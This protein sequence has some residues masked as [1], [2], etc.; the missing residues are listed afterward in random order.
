MKNS[1]LIFLVCLGCLFNACK[2]D[3]SLNAPHKD[4]PIVYGILNYQDSIHYVKI[5]RGFQPSQGTAFID[6]QN[7]DSIYYYNDIKV[8]LQEYKG[9]ARTSRPDIPLEITHDFPRDAGIFYYDKERILYTAKALLNKDMIY[10]I[11]ISNKLTGNEINGKTLL[12][13]DFKIQSTTVN[14]LAP[15]PAISFSEAT[16]AMDYEI[17]VNFM[18]FEVDIKTNTVVK[19]DTIVKNICPQ[20]GGSF[21]RSVSGDLYKNY[22]PTFYDDIVAHVKPNSNVVRY[23]GSPRSPGACIEVEAWAAGESLKQFLLANKPTSSFVQVNNI[24]T[25]LTAS[26]DCVF[27]FLSSRTKCGSEF[28]VTDTSADSL[29]FG[30]KTRHLGFR[31]WTE[32]KP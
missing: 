11:N 5:Y 24:Y 25:N 18:Y 19:M 4:V 20:I 26:T 23:I 12:V 31:P 13:G 15:N 8:V 22:T 21:N 30:R 9:E 32:Y 6:A 7:P 14:M 2:P 3:F 27:G 28:S 10:N 17:H 29:Y 1:C 16:N